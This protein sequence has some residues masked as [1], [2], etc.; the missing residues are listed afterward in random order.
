MKYRSQV[1]HLCNQGSGSCLYT[2][3]LSMAMVEGEDTTLSCDLFH[4]CAH[5]LTSS[6]R[7][8]MI[9]MTPNVYCSLLFLC[10]QFS[11]ETQPLPS[12]KHFPSRYFL[13][14]HSCNPIPIWS[15]LY[16]NRPPSHISK[17][18]T[19]VMLF[20]TNLLGPSLLS[21]SFPSLPLPRAEVTDSLFVAREQWDEGELQAWAFHKRLTPCTDLLLRSAEGGLAQ[22]VVWAMSN[23]YW[24]I[25]WYMMIYDNICVPTCSIL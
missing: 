6:G 9:F 15:N 5:L 23:I 18:I 16:P 13:C 22:R 12:I 8:F 2:L 1:C 19:M 10:S 25:S 11:T 7:S 4:L 20:I 17:L 3:Y 21:L 14:H 24:H